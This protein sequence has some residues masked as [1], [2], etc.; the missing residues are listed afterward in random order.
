[1]AWPRTAAARRAE[2]SG[3]RTWAAIVASVSASASRWSEAR[4]VAWRSE[5][6]LAEGSVGVG[7]A[8][9]H[10][11]V[12][13]RTRPVRRAIAW[14]Q[15]DD[16]TPQHW[17]RPQPRKR[18]GRKSEGAPGD[19]DAAAA[20]AS[21]CEP[22]RG[23]GATKR[24]C[25]LDGWGG[26]HDAARSATGNARLHLLARGV[27]V[28][29]PKRVHGVDARVP[30]RSAV[31]GARAPAAG[32]APAPHHASAAHHLGPGLMAR[33]V[34]NRNK[35]ALPHTIT[36]PT[37]STPTTRRTTATAPRSQRSPPGSTRTRRRARPRCASSRQCA[38]PGRRPTTDPSQ[39][40]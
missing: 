1:M 30:H 6:G 24:C 2:G 11:R 4:S 5:A 14:L 19:S 35:Y 22:P 36:S 33:G 26:E 12:S 10:A 39:A 34:V 25:G 18:R 13:Q 32:R 40:S 3:T 17:P 23:F 9:A 38:A 28:L 20:D 31:H 21:D 7:D 16:A 15:L 27:V 29:E 8:I 37:D